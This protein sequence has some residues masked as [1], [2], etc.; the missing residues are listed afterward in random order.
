MSLFPKTGLERG[1]NRGSVSANRTCAPPHLVQ[2]PHKP[3]TADAQASSDGQVVGYKALG[4]S[5]CVR[6]SACASVQYACG[7]AAAC[8]PCWARK[9]GEVVEQEF[10]VQCRR[11]Q[12]G[13]R[14]RRAL[15]FTISLLHR[16]GISHVY[17]FSSLCRARGCKRGQNCSESTWWTPR[18]NARRAQCP[19][20]TSVSVC[21][22]EQTPQGLAVPI[23]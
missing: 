23:I 19:S 18:I 9:R 16:F 10:R 3:L 11:N 4:Q 12:S 2:A 14:S 20:W 17:S 1:Q 7:E 13:H 21:V 8:C 5:E 6:D 22:L 15:A